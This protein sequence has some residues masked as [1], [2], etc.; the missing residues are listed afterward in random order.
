MDPVKCMYFLA[1]ILTLLPLPSFYKTE[2]CLQCNTKD[3]LL[4][5]SLKSFQYPWKPAETQCI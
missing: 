2:V 1:Y 3:H 5:A 4:K